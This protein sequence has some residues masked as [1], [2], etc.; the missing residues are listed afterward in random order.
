MEKHICQSFLLGL[1]CIMVVL[2][3]G[4]PT[5]TDPDIDCTGHGP[6]VDCKERCINE[7]Y[8][9]GGA[10]LGFPLCCCMKN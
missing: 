5:G 3:S 6:C 7:G 9:K 10:C 1:F 4:L 2:A 8:K